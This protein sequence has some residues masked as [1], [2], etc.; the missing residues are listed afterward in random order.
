MNTLSVSRVRDRSIYHPPTGDSRR[1][2]SEADQLPSPPLSAPR[3][4]SFHSNGGQAGYR[5]NQAGYHPNNHNQIP[6]QPPVPA[7]PRT[8]AEAK[9]E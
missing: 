3:E 9:C 8:E 5:S 2:G 6:R 7:I 4:E 1:A